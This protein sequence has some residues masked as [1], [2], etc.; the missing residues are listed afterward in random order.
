MARH[1]GLT[2]YTPPWGKVMV[3]GTLFARMLAA[4]TVAYYRRK[5]QNATSGELLATP[6]I[7]AR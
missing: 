1:T 2:G 7:V 3:V 6:A 4:L 5:G